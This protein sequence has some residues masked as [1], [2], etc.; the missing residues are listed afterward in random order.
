[1]D[2]RE[3]D[4]PK[5]PQ[6]WWATSHDTKNSH[7]QRVTRAA[8]LCHEVPVAVI[9]KA[10]GR[11]I[12][13]SKD[14]VPECARLVKPRHGYDKSIIEVA[15]DCASMLEG[16]QARTHAE[17]ARK[18]ELSRPAVT[19]FLALLSL[20]PEVQNYLVKTRDHNGMIRAR[21]LR[22]LL[23]IRDRHQQIKTFRVLLAELTRRFS[24]GNPSPWKPAESG[25]VPARKRWSR[26]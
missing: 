2:R 11:C 19:K 8:N 24:T 4:S 5:C 7:G 12:L 22:A 15:R 25:L 26:E 23:H 18:L 10:N 21:H 13:L 1:L 14:K 16:G 3:T 9:R 20:A 6:D 17:L